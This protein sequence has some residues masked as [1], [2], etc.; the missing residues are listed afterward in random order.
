MRFRLLP[1]PAQ[2]ALLVRHC[3]DAR[4][5][6]NLGLEQRSLY[7]IRLRPAPGYAE[8]NRQLT[9][10]RAEH[11]W[12]AAGSVTVQQQALR[13]LDQAFRNFFGKSHRHPAWRRKGADE[14][15]RVVG[16]KP[17]H[18][19]RVSQHKGVV[20]I[21]KVGVV[22]FSWSRSV[23][24]TQSFRVTRDA[25][26]R[27]HVA[28]AVRPPAIPGPGDGSTV[29]LD[30]GVRVSVTVS[31]GQTF[32]MPV[33]L[34]PKEAERLLR[35]QRRLARAQRGSNRRHRLKRSIARV[36]A[37]ETD[38]RKD[39]VEQTTTTLARRYDRIHVE[40]LK[41]KALTRSARGTV[42]Q[43]GT[44]VRVQ[45]RFNRAALGQA[46]GLFRTRLEHKAD[47]RSGRVDPQHTSERCSQCGHVA[48]ESRKNQARVFRCVACGF[49]LD[50]DLNAARNIAGGPPVPA[51]GALG[52]SS[53]A[54]NREPQGLA[55][56]A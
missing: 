43:P 47:G 14:G 10:A 24:P 1:T 27:W 21:P 23:P 3:A 6:W 19:R 45:A 34:R 39:W 18:I 49:K 41:V 30:L 29:G 16:V 37:R 4:Y 5:V 20:Q 51:R 33:L 48:A 54:T 25:A 55:P 26:G 13:D 35:L 11:G 40:D 2:T 32:R 31:D 28:F 7:R 8:Q 53:R 44:L 46:W 12:L 38:R 52:K 9:A 15:F 22:K 42:E 56:V 36:R 50:A 17:G